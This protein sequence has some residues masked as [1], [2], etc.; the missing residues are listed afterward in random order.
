LRRQIEIRNLVHLA[1]PPILNQKVSINR[2]QY[3][4]GARIWRAV[5]RAR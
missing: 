2:P 5:C 1:K 3:A 4:F